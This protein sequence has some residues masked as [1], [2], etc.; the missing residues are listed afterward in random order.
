MSLIPAISRALDGLATAVSP[1]WGFARA[2]GRMAIS[3]I[4]DSGYAIPG[5]PRKAMKG[6]TATDNSPSEDV[7]PG[8]CGM[9]AMSRDL[10]MNAPLATSIL[11]RHKALTIGSGLQ[12]QALPDYDSLGVES[13]DGLAEGLEREFDLLAESTNSD[14]DG[15][16]SFGANQALGYFNLLLNGDFFFM[17]VWREP[18]E[19]GFPYELCVKLIDADLVR[20][21][22]NESR[23]PNQ[24]IQGGVAKDKNTGELLGYHVWDTYPNDSFYTSKGFGKSKFIPVYNDSGYK[25][26]YHVFDP[27]RINQR[28]GVPLLANVSESLKQL[29]RL[30]E[31]E[32]MNA[33]VSSFFTAFVRDQSGMGA[34][35]GPALTPAETVAG[36]GRYGPGEAEVGERNDEDGNDLEMGHGNVVYLDD[37]KDI[38]IAEPNK[39]DENFD[40]FW[41]SLAT[42]IC[43]AGNI[44]VEQAT[45]KYTTSYTAARAA[46]NDVWRHRMVDRSLIE[47]K[48]C[49]P[50]YL[51]WMTEAAVKGRISVPGFFD[52]YSSRR[53]WSRSQWV[54]TGQGSLDPLREGK[55]S[56]LRINSFT[57][58]HDE[59]YQDRR[60]GRWDVAMQKRAREKDLLEKL[61]LEDRPDPNDL[62]GPDGQQDE[63]EEAEQ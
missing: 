8:L 10:F 53:A 55:A 44:P 62:I 29:T 2:R 5:S 17:P 38:T 39:T 47:K 58:T 25:Q 31:A 12:V 60:G 14:F 22:D 45:M 61:G 41:Q 50:F 46:A 35:L 27:E 54:G 4:S 21:P 16:N 9:R 42:Q 3:A 37:Q 18:K 11:R 48:F 59:E 23:Y 56:A 43:A 57:G 15:I 19:K 1:K 7:I 24:D 28:R 33:L 49:Q 30:S 40:A 52:D 63:E 51:E 6:V 34:M 20:D 26:I 13:T 36:G 32:L